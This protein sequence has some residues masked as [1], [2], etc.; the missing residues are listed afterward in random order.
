MVILMYSMFVASPRQMRW[1][2]VYAVGLFG[3]VMAVM[4]AVDRQGY[5]PAIELGHFLL[6][7]T[8]LPAVS[9]WP[10]GCRG[11]TTARGCNARAGTGAGAAA[12]TNTRDELTGRP[13]A[14]TWRR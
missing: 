3:A 10:G 12:R 2:S 13:T 5:P 4:P 1:I 7:A 8:M 14:A 6:V 11:C 9:T